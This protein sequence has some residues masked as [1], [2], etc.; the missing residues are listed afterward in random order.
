[1]KT[2][3]GRTRWLS[4]S[5]VFIGLFAFYLP[6]ARGQ[7]AGNAILT[8]TIQDPNGSIIVGA[9]VII[10]NVETGVAR[11]LTTNDEG[12]Y[13]APL[14]QPGTYEIRASK[15]GF[16]EVIR[17]DVHL[18]VGQ[19]LAI[20]LRL[21]LKAAQ[22]SVTVTGEVGVVET[23]KSDV[24][25]LITQDQVENLPLNGR[26]W[27]NLVLLTPGVSEDG[28]FGGVS[29]RGISSL[30]N[31]NMVDGADNN[32]AFFAEA[33]GRT[34]LPYGYSLDAIKEFQVTN[35]V[36]S[37]EYGRAAGGVVNAITRSG[38]NQF[39]GDAFYFVRDQSFLAQDPRSKEL[40]QQKPDERRQ[41]FGGAFGGP[42]VQNKLFFFLNYDQQ[43]RNFPAVIGPF[44]TGSYNA[45]KSRCGV[46]IPSPNCAGVI[47]AFDALTFTTNP[48]RGDN[49]LGLGKVDYQLNN[50][51]RISTVFNILRWNSPNGIFTGPVLTSTELSNGTDRVSNEFITTS[52]N[53]II[54]QTL[55]ND[56]RFQYGRDFEAQDPNASGPAI[57][58]TGA[59]NIG[60]SNF[61][62]RGAFPNEKRFQWVDNLSWVKGRHVWKFGVDINYVRDNIQNLFQGGGVYVYNDTSSGGTVTNP[63]IQKLADDIANGT[64]QWASFTQAVDPITGSGKGFFTTNDINFYVQ[65]N[66]KV[67]PN[68]SLNLGL[69]YELQ[70]MPG[71]VQA[72][73]VVPETA[74][75]NTDMNNF[76]PR[77]GF[78]YGI[79]RDQKTVIRG[80][81]GMY[82]GRTQNSS[83]F[84]S[85]FQNGVFQQTFRLTSTSA[86][87][88]PVAPNL[89]FPQPSTAPAFT[90]IFG[91]QGGPTPTSEF[92]SLQAYLAACPNAASQSAVVDALSP[93]FVDP[94]VH[95]Y[96]LAVE[97]EL[98]GKLSLSV[99]LV[100]ARG[101]RLP[102]F[103]D[104][105]LAPP[106]QTRTYSILDSTGVP[107]GQFTV[108][109]FS[110]SAP[111]LNPAVGVLL[112]GKSVIN[113]WYNGLVVDVKRRISHGFSFDANFTW[114]Q[115]RDTGQ[116]A[117]VNGTF[118]GTVRALNPYDLRAEA[119]LSEIDMRRRLIIN[120]YWETPFAKWT[121][122]A[123]VKH[124]VGGWRFSSIWRI[125]DGR[126]VE[127]DLSNRPTCGS[128]ANPRNGSLTCGAV[129]GNGL[130]VNG[131]IPFI[132]RNSIFTGPGFFDT[133]MRVSREFKPTE[134]TRLEFLWEAFNVFNRYNPVP[135]SGVFAVD[136]L[137]YSFSAPGAT[138]VAPTGVT[139]FGGCVAPR[140]SFGTV[141]STGN[142]LY[143]AR[144][145][146]FGLKFSF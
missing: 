31:N 85:L 60:M 87:G 80:G 9:Q 118:A 23:E 104:A 94:L 52:W 49:Y 136:N 3:C 145:M 4:C 58:V 71:I 112:E 20:D 76:G 59:A 64:R 140:A 41:Q 13:A 10:K 47:A 15:Q 19:T 86:C 73:P 35:A 90:P 17:K 133:D 111:R 125:Q 65:D 12:L 22:E 67:R 101:L 146:Q 66:I 55:V 127:A 53:S 132:A 38:T 92:N 75:L 70:T 139:N 43:K 39:H 134:R 78:S 68:F 29:F 144:Q 36:Y 26:R 14:L 128:A 121:D 89:L 141:T 32:Q 2:N 102:V 109:F 8:G 120:N 40:G 96:D 124:I 79:G 18:A 117:G 138:C 110:N 42:L 50:S 1:M 11:T 21:P 91:S 131:R 37:A 84:V 63:A 28:G 34:R 7:G 30:Y 122:N 119:G 6:G 115:A 51:N 82:Y 114:S 83:L 143:T 100:G 103:V 69:R 24:S 27:D 46:S 62:P 129:D 142:T 45:E 16:A 99:S 44:S 93:D 107:T 81:Y 25:T 33:R 72:N 56:L 126:P 130:A 54:S 5:L 48:R 106:D 113:S 108:P 95:E 135:S 88:A 123:T 97:R 105:N 74:S 61:L 137:A 116:V 98:P 77:V 57:Q